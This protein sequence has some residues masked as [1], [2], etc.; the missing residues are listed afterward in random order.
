MS[1]MNP[2]KITNRCQVV[3]K[4]DFTLPPLTFQH[5]GPILNPMNKPELHDISLDSQDI[6]N[7]ILG[8]HPPETSEFTF[9]NLFVWRTSKKTRFMEYGGGLILTVMENN[10]RVFMPPL[11]IKDLNSVCREL[12]ENAGQWD[13]SPV[14]IRMG[15]LDI[16]RLDHTG[17]S[18]VEDRD[19]FDYVYL[20]DDLASLKGRRYD[21]KRGFV[22][23]FEETCNGKYERFDPSMRAECLEVASAWVKKRGN[24]EGV[25]R[26]FEAIREYLNSWETFGCCGAVIKVDGKIAGFTFGEHLNRDTMVIHFEKCDTECPGAYQAINQM[27]VKNEI[28]G[29]MKYVNREQDL[30]IEGIRKAKLS[31]HPVKMI[32]KYTVTA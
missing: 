23:K 16:N 17:L 21:G 22:A 13:C 7:S 25:L 5:P 12:L 19:N 31:Y 4:R 24:D 28:A 2:C 30:G 20:A 14:I 1:V 18:V 26:E 9:S 8:E 3:K 15:D 6:F 32:R 11:G 10:R 29:K 27:F